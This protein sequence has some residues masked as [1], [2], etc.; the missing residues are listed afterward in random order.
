MI[1]W[2]N[3]SNTNH[4]FFPWNPFKR[5]ISNTIFR[6]NSISLIALIRSMLKGSNTRREVTYAILSSWSEVGTTIVDSTVSISSLIM[7]SVV[8]TFMISHILSP[9]VLPSTHD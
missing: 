8:T 3:S 9:V 6:P 4:N 5:P 7:S 2:F 1:R